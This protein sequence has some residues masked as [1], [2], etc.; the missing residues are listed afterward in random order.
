MSAYANLKLISSS[1]NRQIRSFGSLENLLT[2]N[3]SLKR[4]H[5]QH[6]YFKNIGLSCRKYSSPPN[7]GTTLTPLLIRASKFGAV[8]IL[9][10]GGAFY[11]YKSNK[12]QEFNPIEWNKGGNGID[13]SDSTQ[14]GNALG[15]PNVSAAYRTSQT[16]P[17]FAP[18]MIIGGGTSAFAA[19]RSIRSNDPTAKV[20]VITEEQHFPYMRPPLSKELWFAEDPKTTKTLR[21]KQWNG[22]E[23]SLFLEQDDFYIL[24]YDLESKETGGVAVLRG[25][26]VVK[27]DPYSSKV[28]LDNNVEIGYEKCLIAT[29]G[30]P[31]NLP[32]F[33]DAPRPLKERISVFR[34]IDHFRDVDKLLK[35]VNSITVIG[36]GF[37][38]SELACAFGR[39]SKKLGFEV[40]QVFP[41]GGNMG[42]VLPEYLSKWA[43]GKVKIEGVKVHTDVNVVGACLTNKNRVLL[44]LSDGEEIE[45]DHVVVAAGLTPNTELAKFAGLEV[46]RQLG[47]YVVN[48]ELEARSNIWVAGDAACFFDPQLGRRRVEHHDH[49]VV[50][51]RLA[52]LNMTG[53]KRPYSHQSMFWSDLGPDVG[54]EAIGVVDAT[55]PTVG[56]FAKASDKD[57][58]KGVVDETGDSIR[59]ETEL[60]APETTPTTLEAKPPK[61]GEEYGKGI[62]FYLKDDVIVG[63]LLWNVFNR[64]SVARK[65]IKEGKKFDDLNEVAK[66]FNIHDTEDKPPA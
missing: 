49:A 13:A 17:N 8:G 61:K 25:R 5:K 2:K 7:L 32:L 36:G 6:E 26:K 34:S 50:S 53:A 19:F 12:L 4:N 15:M 11:L 27:V 47:G 55:L 10:T 35:K 48:S 64:M 31:R 23:R 3:V 56:V 59:S 52:G 57:S 22:K 58:P 51:G 66:L 42:S 44:R 30:T 29:G 60:R 43:T 14:H 20:L 54:Y 9:L 63:I 1:L 41:E 40:N 21:F 37:L 24:P 16:P 46:D 65:V 39:R 28:T 45:T 62:V 18:Y 33:E 38:G